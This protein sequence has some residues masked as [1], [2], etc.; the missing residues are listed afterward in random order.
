MGWFIKFWSIF[1]EKPEF[2]MYRILLTKKPSLK[3][4]QG[5]TWILFSFQKSGL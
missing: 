4:K 2:F 5:T 1:L 3:L